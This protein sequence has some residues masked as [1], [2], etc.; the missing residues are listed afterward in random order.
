M[1]LHRRALVV[2]QVERRPPR[3]SAVRPT[4][5]TSWQMAR[6]EREDV[7]GAQLPPRPAAARAEGRTASR[8]SSGGSCGTGGR[9]TWSRRRAARRRIA[10]NCAALRAEL[11][12]AHSRCSTPRKPARASAGTA[13]RWSTP[14]SCSRVRSDVTERELEQVEVERVGQVAQLQPERRQRDRHH[15]ERRVA[16]VLRREES[17]RREAADERLEPPVRRQP[18]RRDAAPASISCSSA[19]SPASEA[20]RDDHFWARRPSCGCPR[21]LGQPVA[22]AGTRGAGRRTNWLS[23]AW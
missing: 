8:R 15:L 17:G 23:C 1:R 11:R 12:A 2:Q 7:E 10:P 20:R 6:E 14:A 22:A 18:R 16:V 4:W 5:S 21:A 19:S 3:K 9:R 13:K